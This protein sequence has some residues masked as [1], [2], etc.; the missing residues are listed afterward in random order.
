MSA[1]GT[2]LF[3]RVA[4]GIIAGFLILHVG[5]LAFF[6]HEKMVEDAGHFAAATAERALAVAEA[7]RA[8][9]ELLSR[10]STPAFE[11]SLEARKETQPDRVWP[12]SDEVTSLLRSRLTSRGFSDAES[13]EVWYSVGRGPMRLVLQLPLDGR[14]LIVRAEGQGARGHTV[15]AV[16]WT[17][18]LGGLVLLAVLLA[19]GRFTRVLPAVADAAERVG[20]DPALELLPEKGPKEIRRLARAFNAMQQRVADLLAERNV[21]L[22]ALSH[23]VRTLVTRLRLRLDGVEDEDLRE[24]S[25]QDVEAITTLLDEALAFSRDQAVPEPPRQVDVPSLLQSLLDDQADLGASTCY[26]GLDSAAILAPPVGLRRAFA[27]LIDNAIRYGG[28]VAVEVKRNEAR[29]VLEVT[30]VDPGP[31]IPQADQGRALQ[32]FQRLEPSRSRSTGG[33]GLG[34]S[35]ARRV[36]ARVGG[37]LGFD[38]TEKGFAV[39]VLLPC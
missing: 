36:I 9:P 25:E 27:N 35:I 7:A 33:S 5:T 2:S 3:S 37:E 26:T 12:H 11:L 23:D 22:G 18:V 24:K 30:F 4:W 34:L 32:P 17:T 16:F 1:D 21:M 13:V 28:A 38:R 10:L 19:T 31:G 8:E 14:W 15:V 20:R 29:G 39:R 6:N